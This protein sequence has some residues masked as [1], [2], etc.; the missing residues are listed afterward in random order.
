MASQYQAGSGQRYQ[1]P[2]TPRPQFQAPTEDDLKLILIQGDAQQL[3][4]WSEDIGK[5]LAEQDGLTSSQLR[6]V[7]GTVRQIQ[8]RWNEEARSRTWN[9]VVLLRPKMAYQA[10]RASRAKGKEKSEGLETLRKVIEPAIVLLSKN[11][12]PTTEQFTNFVNFFEAIVAYHTRYD[13]KG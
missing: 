4:K 11:S 8:M 1:G 2:R 7:F 12:P 10:K 3:V 13:K 9:E 5:W 6:N